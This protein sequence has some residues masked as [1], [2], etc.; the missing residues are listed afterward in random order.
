M[1]R[2][3]KT[4]QTRE[5]EELGKGKGQKM[6]NWRT[7]ETGEPR[8]DSP[9]LVCAFVSEALRERVV[10]DLQLGDLNGDRKNGSESSVWRGKT[11]G[12]PVG[13]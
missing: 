4:R 9:F 3:I 12:D 5:P 13:S 8:E 7:Q 11:L 2:D 1:K 6:E 10:V